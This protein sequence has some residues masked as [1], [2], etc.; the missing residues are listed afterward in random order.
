MVGVAL[1]GAGVLVV[2]FC[3]QRFLVR[4][5]AKEHKE[6]KQC[7]GNYFDTDIFSSEH[8][9]ATFIESNYPTFP[10]SGK[11]VLWALSEDCQPWCHSL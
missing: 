7:F 4:Q 3:F 8:S 10:M 1:V 5:M 9:I 11:D 6:V 2:G